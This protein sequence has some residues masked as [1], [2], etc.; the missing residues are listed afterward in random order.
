MREIT[1]LLNRVEF[2][3]ALT[4]IFLLVTYLSAPNLSHAQPPSPVVAI[5][6]S[7]LTQALETTPAASP[8]PTGPGTSGYQWWYTSWHYFVAYESLKEALRSD[9]TPFV[10]VSDSDIAAGKLLDSDGSPHYP[11]LISLASEAIADNEISPLRN[12][13]NA[14]GFL[15]AGSSAFTRNPDGSSRGDFAL[16]NEMGVHMANANLQNWYLNAQFTKKAD[17]RLTSH[18]PSGTLN[19]YGPVTANEISWGVSPAH[20]I[21]TTHYAWWVVASGATDIA[22]GDAGPLL[23]VKNYG[24]GQFIY[25][26][27]FQ[28]LIG[29]GGNDPGMYAYLI[30]RK[31]IE[32]AFASFTLPIVKVSPWPYQYDAAFINRHDFENDP[33]SIRLIESSA[34]FEHSIGVKGDYYFSTGALREDM[35]GNAAVIASLKNAV[36]NYGA[37]IGSHNGGL[38]NPVNTTL[39]QTDYDYWHWGPDEALDTTP[40]GYT[41]G[42]AYA[43]ASI[44]AS[45]Q[46]IEGWLSGLDNGRSGCGIL[47]NCPRTFVSPYFNST[48][49]DSRDI[50]DQL[51][52][53]VMGE[54]KIG[55]FPQ[56]TFSY[57]TLGK[58]YSPITLPVSDWYVGPSIAQA[59]DG[60]FD[61]YY[62]HT[63]DSIKAAIDF[64]YNL[65]LLLN[66]YTHSPSNDGVGQDYVTHS[67]SKAR[68]WSNN[69]VGISDWWRV[70]SNVAVT[71]T[72]TKTGV[73][74]IVTASVSGAT[75]PATAIEISLPQTQGQ[76]IGDMAV[77]LNGTPAAP[78]NYR[79]TDYGIK[80][81]VGA[82]VSSVNVQYSYNQPPVASNDSFS[83]TGN[84]PFTMPAPGVLINDS[85]PEGSSLTA[86][87]VSGPSHG[88]LTL[89]NNGS[90]AYTPVANYVGIDSFT[91][92]ANDGTSN[93]NIA[94]VTITI[95]PALVSVDLSPTTVTGGSTSQGTVTLSGPAPSG[96]VVVSLSDNSS[97]ASEPSSVTVPAGSTSAT[98]TITTTSV[99]SVTPVTISAVYG[100]VTKSATL[101]LAV[102]ASGLAIDATASAHSGGLTG[103]TIAAPAF[104]TK[105]ENDLLLAFISAS[106]I[107]AAPNINVTG[108]SGGGLTWTLVRRTNN[109]QGA[110]EIWQAFATAPLTNATATAS[111]SKSGA[112]ASITVVAFAGVNVTTPVGAVGGDSAAS[113]APTASLTTQGANSWVFGV[114]NDWDGAVA[115]TVGG[116]QTMVYQ[117]L[118]PTGDTFWVQRQ[119]ATVQPAGTVVTISDTAPTNHQWNLSIIEVRALANNNFSPVAVN[120]LYSTNANTALNQAAPGVLNNDTDPQ[121]VSLTA[122]LVSGPSHG[123]LTLNTNGSFAYAPAASYVGSDSFT[124]SANNGTNSSNVAMVTIAVLPSLISVDVSPTIVTGG[125]TSQGTVTLS[126]PAPSGG[127]VVSLSDNSSAAGEPSSVTVPAGSTSATFTIATNS[128]TSVTPV[129]IS[130]VYGGVTKSATLTL[131]VSVL[132]LSIDAMTSVDSGGLTGSTI[133][134][135]AFTTKAG[136]DLLLAFIS[137]SYIGA[138]PNINV[139]G[140]SGGGLTWTL[141]RRTNTQ[142][143]ASEIW[144]AFATAPLTNATVTASLSKSG[145]AASITVVAFAGVN[146]TTPVGAVGGGS[147]ATGA[148]TA[149]LTTQGADS[150]VFGVGN[151]WD[152]V[153][154]RTVGGSQAVVYQYLSPTGDTFWVQRQ[155]A[156]VQPAGTVVT[157]NDT[158]P[159]NH[160]WNLS[161]VEVRALANNLSP[162]AVN[163]LYSTNANTTLNQA[164]PGVLNNDADPEGATLTAQL[165]TGPSH[166][167][168]TL[169]ANGSFSYTPTTN[170]TGSDNF[171][172][173]ANDGTSIS[174]VSVA[175]IAV[176]PSLVSIGFSPASV[177]G[178][179]TSQGT[180]TLS[181]TAP[182]GGLAV[183]LSSDSASATVPASVTIASGSSSATFTV[184]TTAVTGSTAATISAVYDGVT[185]TAVLTLDP[186]AASLSTIAIS[187]ASVTGGA[188]T[189]G[190][191]TLSAPAPSGGLAVALSSDSLS[192]TVPASVTIA[193]GSSSATFTVATTAVT[194][195]TAA[196]ISAVYDGITKTAVLTLDAPP[197][198]LSTIAISP[199]SVTG[200]TTSQGTVTLSAPAPVGGL[201]VALSSDSSAATVPASVTI[202]SGSS[203]TTFTVTTT[204]VTGSTAATISAVYDGITKT[205]VLTLDAPPVILSTIAISPASVT[206]GAI[207]QG[208]MTL[209]AP[210]PIG[211]MTVALSSDSSSPPFRPA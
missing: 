172:Y 127:V 149:S 205:A 169:N 181:A 109:Q 92:M 36:S 13:V 133:V 94:T 21:D 19:W 28:P 37:T 177:T 136:N 144:K 97:A 34:Q 151:D 43:S 111:L 25:H 180:V 140:V 3:T 118:S 195:S 148:P 155:N 158:A 22:D 93:S 178:G 124:Y 103:S 104:T 129:T 107:G 203:S 204:A 96:G 9:G 162:V 79:T 73:T 108:V 60:P 190:T 141:V 77:F 64:Y 163:D 83:L 20:T 200:G 184:T 179:T 183:A 86:Q 168:L 80:V 17:H 98:F 50:V 68:L 126:G 32:W 186:P 150:W 76:S 39:L 67:M 191:L 95:L 2:R 53:V 130:A 165:V 24:M 137:A 198:I 49:D 89:N 147:A 48:R 206:G 210:V 166:G 209:S 42:K 115:R 152:G 187:P 55:P 153:V 81:L 72:F 7:E 10:E 54:Q 100:E 8:T 112:A 84:S 135:P 91:Y 208:T 62:L 170:Y 114:G 57:N 31:A 47:G 143:G 138:A 70:R 182:S 132:G 82:T 128:V 123:T 38:K 46:D 105:T 192:A 14:G 119:N 164:A 157:I 134:A 15:L 207:T 122:Q 16:A 51:G 75:D 185:K 188:T 139:T 18:I 90:F 146:V 23:T 175:T 156:T 63:T 197:V 41:N 85:D 66:F 33:A 160:Q 102:S 1:F 61:D 99:T 101:T 59:I 202:A 110:S 74:S 125:S 171:S 106:Y 44:L 176:L 142:Q 121:G 211:G 173:S 120:D 131:T 52:S 116:S 199:A 26:G 193:S 58:F 6:V 113:G 87:R 5:H 27:A 194:G 196:I 40:Q 161:I 69:S 35:G 29:H 201:T 4:A 30:Y 174:N 78:S 45:F 11:I 56:K 145:A 117:Y 159:T 65:G 12:Y 189:Q 154:A 71:P 167:T 88:T